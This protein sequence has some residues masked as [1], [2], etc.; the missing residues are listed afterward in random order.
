MVQNPALTDPEEFF[1]LDAALPVEGAIQRAQSG[2]WFEPERP[3]EKPATPSFFFFFLRSRE[4]T[5]LQTESLCHR[6]R[7]EQWHFFCARDI[8]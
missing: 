3:N 1:G 2:V 6:K 5:Y 4:A 7:W 8:I